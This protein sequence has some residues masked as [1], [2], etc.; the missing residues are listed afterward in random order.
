MLILFRWPDFDNDVR[1]DKK[2]TPREHLNI[3]CTSK[4]KNIDVRFCKKE[5]SKLGMVI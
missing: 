2:Y 1:Q 4:M 5:K 3:S